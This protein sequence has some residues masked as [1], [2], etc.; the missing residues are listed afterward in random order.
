MIHLLHSYL[1]HSYIPHSIARLEP[2]LLLLLLLLHERR[3]G[4]VLIVFA[5]KESVQ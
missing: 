4:H 5:W 2:H 3:E 1:I